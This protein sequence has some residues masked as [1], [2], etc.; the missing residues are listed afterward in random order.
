MVVKGRAV[1]GIETDVPE[2]VTQFDAAQIAA[3]GAGNISDL[4]K[5]TPNVEIRSAG[6]TTSVFFIRGVG[7]ADFSSNA[8]GA[9][10]IYLDGVPL[11]AP[12]L[13]NVALFDTQNVD[14]KRG[15]QGSGLFRNAS[16]GAFEISS[17]KP[18]MEYEAKLR[19]TT[20]S[21]WSNDARNAFIRDTEGFVNL[22]VVEDTLAARV[23]FRVRR[24]DPF[25]SNGCANAPAFEDRL[26]TDFEGQAAAAIC[27]E[28]KSVREGFS[29]I[30]TGLPF[31]VGDR[32][33][34]AARGM[35]RFSP[36]DADMDWLLNF[37]GGRLDQDSTLGQAIGVKSK[38]NSPGPSQFGDETT[39]GYVEPDQKAEFDEIKFAM[40][41]VSN[42]DE[43]R[44][45]VPVAEKNRVLPLAWEEFGN[46]LTKRPLDRE[47]YRG[48][49]NKVGQTTRDTF[50]VSLRGEFPLGGDADF[51]TITAYESYD[52]FR[53]SDTDFIPDTVFEIVTRDAA[54]QFS[55]DLEIKGQVLEGAVRWS[56]GASFLEEKLTNLSFTDLDLLTGTPPQLRYYTQKTSAY[57]VT[58]TVSWDFLDDFTLDVGGRFNYE[59]K[60]FEIAEAVDVAGPV[61]NTF[62]PEIWQEPTGGISLRYHMNDTTTMFAKYTHGFKAGHFNSNSAQDTRVNGPARPE[63]IDAFEWGLSGI[64]LEDRLRLR[65]AFFFYDY[66]DYQV[67]VF[68]DSAN[69]SEAP[70]LVI[71]NAEAAQQYGAELDLTLKPLQ[72]WVP[73]P[74][75]GLEVAV[76]FGWLASQ[77][78][79]FGNPVFRKNPEFPA[80][81][82]A[83]VT[84][85][86]SRHRL[87]NSPEFTVSGHLEWPFD[88]GEW[89]TITPRYDVRWSSEIFFD[90]SEGRGTL[91]REGNAVLPEHALG[92]SAYWIH[93][94]SLSYRTPIENIEV[95][96]WVRNLL[97]TRYKTFAFDASSFS[98]AVLN[99]VGDPRSAGVDLTITW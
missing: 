8:A 56:A 79:E 74:V 11:N 3:L 49:Y 66:R 45:T 64:W 54:K 65:T 39:T 88:F 25:M 81:P 19:T 36:P 73:D 27:G 82:P 55:Q 97:D 26:H 29:V 5:V 9:V 53:D 94:V 6:A 2:S 23:A 38:G 95:R 16:A 32:G 51:T 62:D 76:R 18:S 21:F 7:L 41:G 86:Y 46:R 13:Q 44:T 22:P 71:R 57:M 87:I 31:K 85:D 40:A 24:T 43:W 58:A 1:S 78:L 4:A 68:R 12:A 17:N 28:V 20:A 89:G 77:F 47:P 92:Q 90:P 33:A 83:E 75:D 59:R 52:R 42:E 15:P 67:F 69:P 80:L 91:D 35:L 50:G 34:W 99:F 48:D 93:N 10:A 63:F 70:S 96:G 14:V 61:T 98:G 84:V 30:P 60:E 72:D 37:H